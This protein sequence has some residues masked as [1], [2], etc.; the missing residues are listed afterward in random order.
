MVEI[1]CLWC[2]SVVRVEARPVEDEV[3]CPECLTRWWFEDDHIE[4]LA[5]AA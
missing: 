5:L 2:E 4:E 1:E 3:T